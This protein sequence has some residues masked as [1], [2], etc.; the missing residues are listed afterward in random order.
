MGSR[1]TMDRWAEAVV[2]SAALVAF[3][4][5]GCGEPTREKPVDITL[6][7]EDWCDRV[8]QLRDT[9]LAS[10]TIGVARFEYK[11]NGLVCDDPGRL[12]RLRPGDD[13]GIWVAN[14]LRYELE[15]QGAH[16]VA[17]PDG[18]ARFRGVMVRGRLNYLSGMLVGY[19]GGLGALVTGAGHTVHVNL[20]LEVV[21]NGVPVMQRV[22]DLEH[23][24][25]AD[26]LIAYLFGIGPAGLAKAI[27][28]TVATLLRQQILPD[29]GAIVARRETPEGAS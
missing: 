6:R 21:D 7:Y 5:A 14:A 11:G 10:Q 2:R 3:A 19:Y 16:V 24:V 23:H 8:P 17:L 20:V 27:P 26:P 25:L 22:Y 15:R 28:V 4:V 1:P 29:I 9:R 18:Y 13:P 12:A